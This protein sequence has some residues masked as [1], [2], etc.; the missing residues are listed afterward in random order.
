MANV[1]S[2]RNPGEGRGLSTIGMHG[3]DT[4]RSTTARRTESAWTPAFAGVTAYFSIVRPKGRNTSFPPR[5][6]CTKYFR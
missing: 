4:S 6:I 1:K 5:R 2:Y 3:C